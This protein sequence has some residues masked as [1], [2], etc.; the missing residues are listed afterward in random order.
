MSKNARKI[1]EDSF[2]EEIVIN[3]LLITLDSL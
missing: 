1:V 3:E 2:D